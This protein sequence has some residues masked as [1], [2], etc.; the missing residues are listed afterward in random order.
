MGGSD[1]THSI[2]TV[3]VYAAVSHKSLDTINSARCEVLPVISTVP[4]LSQHSIAYY[5]FLPTV[6]IDFKAILQCQA[7]TRNRGNGRLTDLEKAK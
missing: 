7:R 5:Y 3:G 6:F 1:S 4:N 2:E